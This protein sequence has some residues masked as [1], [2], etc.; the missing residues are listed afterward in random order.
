MELERVSE[1]EKSGTPGCA[2]AVVSPLK[3]Q[4]WERELE[5]HP[6]KEWMKF[7]V[8][9]IR[10]GFRLGHDQSVVEVTGR[11]GGMYKALEHKAIIDEYLA[12]EE[13]ARRI[14]RISS[15]VDKGRVQCS[16]F[17][18]IPK[19]GK[20]GKWRLIVNLSAP[21]GRSVNDGID[22]ELASVQYLYVD[23]VVRR[24]LQLGGGAEIAKA[25]V[26]MAYRNV[27]VHPRDRWLLG[28]EWDGDVFV[29]GALPFGL[30]SAPLLFTALGDAIEWV[31]KNRGAGWLGHY[32]DDF[33]AV[34]SRDTGEC[35]RTMAVF[36]EAC[37]VL[38]MPLDP[39]KEEG[40][41]QVITFLGMELD[42]RSMVVRLPEERLKAL[43]RM[44]RE[45]RGMK[46][47]T[48]REL[49]SIVGHL[50]FASRAVR[51]GRAF[52]RRLVDL[53]T[54][55]KQRD[56]RVR[57]NLSARADLEWWWQ[58][59]LQWNGVTM[60]LKLTSHRSNSCQ[61]PLAHGGV[62]HGGTADGSSCAGNRRQQ[63]E[64][65]ASCQKK[66]YP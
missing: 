15:S 24:V 44:L 13:R 63:R 25:D 64:S 39:A 22:K 1:G 42:T 30:R 55:V 16:P 59:G 46:S 29:D 37:E 20:P 14:W 5:E 4:E 7:L 21:D 8:R 38:G 11:R 53:G 9:G 3:W 23:D 45:W 6:D 43:K 57:L 10:A 17:G 60:M 49:E 51:P 40:P 2:E 32:I 18:V 52:M 66:C 12:K 33:V 56:R 54:T 34:G 31:A 36:K 65:G 62:G 41:A 19:K 28:M 26:S 27:P 35:A 47:C 50:R 61:M 58:F 48:R